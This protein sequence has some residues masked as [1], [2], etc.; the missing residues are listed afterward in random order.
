[1]LF[2]SSVS[3]MMSNPALLAT[4]FL[5]DSN[6]TIVLIEKFAQGKSRS[7]PMVVANTKGTKVMTYFNK[8]SV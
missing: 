4:S 3:K 7:G 1:M 6:K 5:A 8:T 2:T